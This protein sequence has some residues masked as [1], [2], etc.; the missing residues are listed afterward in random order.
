MILGL[1]QAIETKKTDDPDVIRIE[2]IKKFVHELD[3][4]LKNLQD[5]EELQIT[6][7]V[8]IIGKNGRIRG[9]SGSQRNMPEYIE[10]RKAVYE[11][12]NFKCQECGKHGRLEAHHIKPWHSHPLLRF[13]INNG[14]TLCEECHK[15]KHPHLGLNNGSSNET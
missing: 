10:W 3:G 5:G 9:G 12:D 14:I 6:F 15:A 2:A 11:R 13:D 7:R 4:K 8:D 1:N